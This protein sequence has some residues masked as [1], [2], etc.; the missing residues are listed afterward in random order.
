[1]LLW[2]T[3][4]KSMTV[5]QMR[6]HQ[7]YFLEECKDAQ[8]YDLLGIQGRGS[9]GVVYRAWSIK[10]RRVVAIKKI[11]N[12]FSSPKDARRI[13]RELK[14]LSFVKHPNIVKLQKVFLPTGRQKYKNI[15]IVLD[16][17]EFD[18]R[19]LIQN[20][21]HHSELDIHRP[22][23]IHCILCGLKYLHENK[24]VHRDIKPANILIS[25]DFS[26]VVLADFG[27]ARVVD[28]HIFPNVSLIHVHGIMNGRDNGIWTQ[29]V[30]TRWYRPPELCEH[31]DVIIPTKIT[32]S[33]SIDVWGAGCIF[34]ELFTHKPLFRGRDNLDQKQ[35]ILDIIGNEML[36]IYTK[37]KIELSALCLIRN[38]LQVNFQKRPTVQEC[39]SYRYVVDWKFH[40]IENKRRSSLEEKEVYKINHNIFKK[41]D[42]LFEYFDTTTTTSLPIWRSEIFIEIVKAQNLHTLDQF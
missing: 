11:I 36:D 6:L 28:D 15:Y 18:L 9:Y 4:D 5:E 35:I 19:T 10:E 33:M 14:L 32:Q 24:I 3:H 16:F 29:Y 30:A 37:F 27:L 17:Y 13:L 42:F 21:E 2:V 31:E 34:A 20:T 38:M 8:D 40:L 41:Q 25:A 1:M 7:E 26:K 12:V 23:I 39:L 22:K